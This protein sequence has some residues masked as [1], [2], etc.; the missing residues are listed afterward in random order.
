MA[1]RGGQ[2]VLGV[3]SGAGDGEADADVLYRTME[4]V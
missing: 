2:L 4:S 3:D 1:K